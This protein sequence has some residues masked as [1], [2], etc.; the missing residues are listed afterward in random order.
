MFFTMSFWT[1]R[2]SGNPVPGSV[3]CQFRAGVERQFVLDFGYVA[4]HGGVRYVQLPRYLLIL[5]SLRY[6]GKHRSLPLRERGKRNKLV[7]L[8][9]LR[10]S[11]HQ[12]PERIGVEVHA[13]VRNHG[14]ASYYLRAACPRGH[15]AGRARQYEMA[16][17]IVLLLL[18]QREYL[19]RG[20]CGL[21][22]V[23][24]EASAEDIPAPAQNDDIGLEATQVRE[25]LSDAGVFAHD[26]GNLGLFQRSLQSKSDN[27][28]FFR[29][30][31][32][33]Q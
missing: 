8:N 15:A 33:Q 5:A 32:V 3:E 23:T 2:A 22:L 29:D 9:L 17:L 13:A 24:G 14:Y 31:G 27:Q 12:A 30:N 19:G 11:Y 1:C 10:N 16:Q 21:Y 4:L 20:R 26:R 18:S 28:V 7:A 6:Q 25:H